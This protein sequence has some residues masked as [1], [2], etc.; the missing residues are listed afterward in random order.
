[1]EP[2]GGRADAL[3]AVS[4]LA[5]PKE[6]GPQNT[7]KDA[8][9]DEGCGLGGPCRIARP[10]I[11]RGTRSCAIRR[12]MSKKRATAIFDLSL[13]VGPQVLRDYRPSDAEALNGVALSAFLQFERYYSDWKA[14]RSGVARMS[15]LSSTAEIIVAEDAGRI[16]G[17]V[18]YVGMEKTQASF[19]RSRLAGH[20]A[21]GSWKGPWSPI[22]RGVCTSSA[23]RWSSTHSVTHHADY[24]SSF[25]DVPK[26]GLPSPP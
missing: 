17:G 11:G 10:D 8:K 1:M 21:S 3:K 4:V 6:W 25:G 18:V 9:G 12:G 26:I 7:R 14:M 16:L 24:G 5:L 13:R 2:S 19:L 20:R 22:D 23:P 15:E